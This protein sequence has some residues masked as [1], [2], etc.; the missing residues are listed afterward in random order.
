V[1]VMAKKGRKSRPPRGKMLLSPPPEPL[2]RAPRT[3]LKIHAG[4]LD[5]LTFTASEVVGTALAGVLGESTSLDEMRRLSTRR[6]ML[7]AMV[8]THRSVR[9]LV[10]SGTEEMEL[11]LDALPLVRVQLERCFLALLL[12]DNPTRWHG[13]YRKN[14]WKA[15]A[16]KFFRDRTAL[17]HLEPYREYFGP[18]GVGVELLMRLAREMDVSNDEFQTLRVQVTG[19]EP[20][21]RF[22]QWFIADMPTPGR[23]LQQLKDPTHQR[24]ATLLYPAYDNLSHFSHGGLV[25]AMEA[26]ILRKELVED[27]EQ[28][29]QRFWFRNVLEFALP[30]SYVSILFVATLF[31]RAYL[32]TPG[33]RKALLAAWRPYH[34]DGSP[35]GIV[36]WDAWAGELLT[37]QGAT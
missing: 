23:C 28:Q 16:E 3:D 1:N 10:G 21:P 9:R 26:A 37:G 4:Q 18:S 27:T 29:R 34:S 14:A 32:H 35:L 15:F 5:E 30:A 12:E 31:A 6:Q 19:E 7:R 20:D 17:G 36:L 13:R 33:V 11:S 25:G 24:L 8:D 22:K 2:G